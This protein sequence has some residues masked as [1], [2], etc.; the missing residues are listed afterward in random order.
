MRKI[1]VFLPSEVEQNAECL[2]WKHLCTQIDREFCEVRIF[3]CGLDFKKSEARFSLPYCVEQ[4]P[5]QE[6]KIKD[7]SDMYQTYI[8]NTGKS[9]DGYIDAEI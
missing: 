8:I 1:H 2:R 5:N 9:E 4:I 6:P 7:F 3:T